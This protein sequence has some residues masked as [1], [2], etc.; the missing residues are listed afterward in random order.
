VVAR[1][2]AV[3][4]RL[5]FRARFLQAFSLH[6]PKNKKEKTK[7]AAANAAALFCSSTIINYSKAIVVYL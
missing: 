5:I 4:L 6:T 1:A 7:S 2:V 3:F